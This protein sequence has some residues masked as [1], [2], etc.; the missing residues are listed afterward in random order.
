MFLWKSFRNRER[1]KCEFLDR[2]YQYEL[3]G[4]AEKPRLIMDASKISTVNIKLR[5]VQVF[6]RMLDDITVK[7]MCNDG[8]EDEQDE[9]AKLKKKML[10]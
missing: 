4:D 8:T 1:R 7:N 5:A 3:H 6:N 2:K 10:K 9:Q